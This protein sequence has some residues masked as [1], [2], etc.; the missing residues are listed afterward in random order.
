[1]KMGEAQCILRKPI[2]FEQ[3]RLS[4]AAACAVTFIAG[5]A[6]AVRSL[7]NDDVHTSVAAYGPST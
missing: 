2:K 7:G 6:A 5:H 3:E 4:D 1:V